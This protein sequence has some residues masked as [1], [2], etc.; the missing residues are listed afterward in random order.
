MGIG[1]SLASLGFKGGS[2]G[3]VLDLPSAPTGVTAEAYF[4]GI[5]ISWAHASLA[6]YFRVYRATSQTGTFALIAD[7]VTVSKYLDN[8][9]LANTPYWY[10]VT[11]VNDAGASSVST[12]IAGRSNP[13]PTQSFSSDVIENEALEWSGLQNY[14]AQT[15]S[16]INGL[17]N[18]NIAI[19]ANIAASKVSGTA[20]CQSDVSAQIEK[21]TAKIP[22]HDQ[23]GSLWLLGATQLRNA[24]GLYIYTD[25]TKGALVFA[26][27]ATNWAYVN[28][29]GWHNGSP[30]SGTAAQKLSIYFDATRTAWV[31]DID[32]VECGYID[33]VNVSVFC[34][35]LTGTRTAAIGEAYIEVSATA[36]NF[37]YNG[38]KIGYINSTGTH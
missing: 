28:A 34:N 32:G 12:T 6:D 7:N 2:S 13:A 1:V 14:F 21:T 8:G 35:S 10:Y 30:G 4:G 15:E 37:Y 3:I 26:G 9:V 5:L 29:S 20:I 27:A 24:D 19:Y 25:Y 38:I 33:P 22:K 11:A 31:I 17:K 36:F 23:N 16:T 18:E